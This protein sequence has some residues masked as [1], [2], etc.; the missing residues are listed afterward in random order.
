MQVRGWNNAGYLFVTAGDLKCRAPTLW[1]TNQQVLQWKQLTESYAKGL[2]YGR[3]MGPQK[4]TLSCTPAP[5]HPCA[6]APLHPAPLHPCTPAPLHTPGDR[7][8]RTP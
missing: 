1:E 7:H 8:W 4:V 2:A 6:P 5:L 3:G